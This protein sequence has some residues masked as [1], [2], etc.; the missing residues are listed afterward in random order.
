MHEQKTFILLTHIDPCHLNLFTIKN[1]FLNHTLHSSYTPKIILKTHFNNVDDSM[2]TPTLSTMT[3]AL[4]HLDER[5][6]MT[7]L[8]KTLYE[9]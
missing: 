7:V 9:N 3:Q 8:G 2:L 4:A 6:G 1:C 5:A